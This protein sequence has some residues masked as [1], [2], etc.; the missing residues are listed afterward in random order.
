MEKTVN[1]LTTLA[2]RYPGVVN[3]PPILF[4]LLFAF[5]VFR[6]GVRGRRSFRLKRCS[7]LLAKCLKSGCC[8]MIFCCLWVCFLL[9]SQTSLARQHQPFN[10]VLAATFG[11]SWLMIIVPCLLAENPK[12]RAKAAPLK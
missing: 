8:L 10:L 1:E 11:L 6:F 5:L 4:I 3:T 9:G 7:Q 12:T 2:E